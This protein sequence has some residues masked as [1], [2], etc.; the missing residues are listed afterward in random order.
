LRLVFVNE[1]SRRTGVERLDLIEKD[2]ILHE[3]LKDLSEGDF[4]KNYLFKGGTCLIKCY[5]GYF[6][7]SEDIDFTWR[8]QSKFQSFS[9]KKLRGILSNMIDEVGKTFEEISTKHGLEFKC[10]KGNRDYVELSGSNKI[11]TFKL[12]YDSETLRRRSFIKMQINFVESLFYPSKMLELRSLLTDAEQASRRELEFLYPDQSNY[13]TKIPFAAYDVREI[14]SEKIRAILTR[15]GI[16]ARDYLDVY[17]IEKKLGYKPEEILE[18]AREKIRLSLKLYDRYRRNFDTKK[19]HI[20]SLS[21]VWGEER[22]LVLEE[23]D[24]AGFYAFLEHFK[25]FLM[26]VVRNIE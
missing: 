13:L 19:E 8:D 21:F 4:G 9:Q 14:L 5:L 2:I 10:L 26:E 6:L 17:I 3:I 7:F 1:V 22:S 24:E 15:E 11:C 18:Q 16:K 25:G 12:W 23:L 20:E